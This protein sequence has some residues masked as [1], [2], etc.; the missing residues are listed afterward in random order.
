MFKKRLKMRNASEN[1][2]GLPESPLLSVKEWGLWPVPAEVVL[3]CTYVQ[4]ILGIFEV[5]EAAFIL[6]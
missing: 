3:G 1:M 6:P 4:G 5:A 2:Q